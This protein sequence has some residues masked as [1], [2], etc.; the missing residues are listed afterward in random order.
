MDTWHFVHVSDIQPGSKRSFRYNPRYDENWQTARRQI[1]Q[2][3][4]ELMVIGGDI[5]R[6]GSI[7]DFEFEEMKASLD[8][9]SIP[10]HA[11]PGN[12][13]TGNKHTDKQG[14]KPERDDI[15]LNVT[16]EQLRRYSRFFGEFPW[17][18]VHRN[19][20]FSGFY[21][22]LAGSGLPEEEQMWQWLDDLKHLPRARHH[23]MTN[24]YALFIDDPDEPN[25]DITKQESYQA[26]YFGINQPYR[27]RI[28]ETYKAAHVEIVFSGHIHCQRPE[29]IVDGMR[30]YKSP[31]TA[32]AQ[33]ADRW[34]DGD[35]KLGFYHCR[36]TDDHIEVSFV[37]LK[38][39]STATGGWG[40]GGHIK[41]EDRDYS[42]AQ[43]S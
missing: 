24:H 6:D 29:Q 33:F 34:E 19:V 31:A 35:P 27:Q 12:M 30:F 2:L 10:Y 4:P 1:M 16:S 3:Q 15:G 9:M 17:S 20:R 23:V 18:F 38:K 7:H 11:I 26:W 5:T 36:V 41:P 43:Q 42:L 13:D 39:E 25:F 37:P 8:S 22:A 14:P 21:A 28:F 40:K 32:M